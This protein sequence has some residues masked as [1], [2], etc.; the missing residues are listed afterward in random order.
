VTLNVEKNANDGEIKKA[1]YVAARKHHPDKNG[2]TPEATAYFQE[3]QHAYTVLSDRNERAWYDSHRE[4][5]LR[6]GTG[7]EVD[8]EK[9]E[10]AVEE[11]DPSPFLSP[12]VF[13]GYGS[14]PKSFYC[15]YKVVF[16][17]IMEHERMA[18]ERERSDK[19]FEPLPEFGDSDSS[20]DDVL[21]FYQC[22]SGFSTK[23]TYSWRDRY[24][25]TQGESRQI[26]R[27]MEKENSKIRATH[28]KKYNSTV[29]M[30]ATFVKRRDRRFDA[31]VEQEKA[32]KEKAKAQRLKAQEEASIQHQE[33]VRLWREEQERAAAEEAARTQ[34]EDGANLSGPLEF[35][36]DDQEDFGV[37]NK[38]KK[39]R[40]EKNRTS[41]VDDG[42]K[43]AAGEEGAGQTD[44]NVAGNGQSGPES[45]LATTM[46][47]VSVDDLEEVVEKKP[48]SFECRPCKK[49]FKSEGQFL[50]HEKSKKH[51]KT[52]KKLGFA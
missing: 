10:G 2:N 3:I 37:G 50:S 23:L 24:N 40:K 8:G 9:G 30:L 13:S 46:E 52:M 12:F 27:A 14:D 16:E 17:Q 45:G 43:K 32:A 21:L 48:V 20:P 34:E 42:D 7:T 18:H 51:I 15:V 49:K 29:R 5:I 28:R 41:E 6:G 25:V 19:V 36:L 1:Y 22:W 31:I 38:K 35:R 4:Q 11:Y 26:R 33:K 44:D 47:Q 39:K